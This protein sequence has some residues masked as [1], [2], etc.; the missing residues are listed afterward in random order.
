MPDLEIR[1]DT[2]LRV[3]H[4]QAMSETGTS[5]VDAYVLPKMAV[6]DAG[7]VIIPLDDLSG[8]LT[9]ATDLTATVIDVTDRRGES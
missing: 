3:A 6:L 8:M 9:A 4:V 2:E 7:R 5:F 1:K